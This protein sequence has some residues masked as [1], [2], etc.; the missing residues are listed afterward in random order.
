MST[1]EKVKELFRTE[2]FKWR[3]EYNVPNDVFEVVGVPPQGPPV[4][5]GMD[6]TIE[7]ALDRAADGLNPHSE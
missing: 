1:D 2:G 4:V 7:G 6:D 3:L 5:H